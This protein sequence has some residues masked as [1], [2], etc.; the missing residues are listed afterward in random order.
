M[1][2]ALIAVCLVVAAAADESGWSKAVIVR[3]GPEQIVRFQARI[4]GGYLLVRSI[5]EDGWH[6]YAMDNE[7]RAAEALRG[8]MSLGIEQGIEI[9]VTSGLELDGRWLQ[10]EPH[11]L[12]RPELRWYTY[13]FEKTSLFACRVKSLTADP[14]V[15][16][17]SGQAC[18]GDT[19][20]Q[21][22][23]ELQLAGI[24]QT[25]D[26][27]TQGDDEQLKAWLAGLVPVKTKRA[28]TEDPPR[29]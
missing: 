28:D 13:G 9:T 22:D 12:S 27:S 16:R 11:D 14:V 2:H 5:H 3:Q 10:T 25:T 17:I 24:K 21:V 19:C 23:V 26:A 20:C 15:L 1:I 18:S 4:H 7:L 6:T 8:K 29:G